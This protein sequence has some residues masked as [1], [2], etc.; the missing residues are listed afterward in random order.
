MKIWRLITLCFLFVSNGSYSQSFVFGEKKY[1]S[2]PG[3]SIFPYF[4]DGHISYGRLDANRYYKVWAG[5]TSY[6]TVGNSYF[7]QDSIWGQGL[8]RGDSADFDNGGAWL[9][10][11]FI[12]DSNYWLGFYHAED[13][14]FPG[15]ANREQIAWKSIAQCVSFD[16]GRTWEKRGQIITTDQIKPNKPTWGGHADFTVV[17]DSQNKR[18]IAYFVVPEGLGMAISEDSFARA[19]TWKKHYNGSFTEPG[20]GGMASALNFS[21]DFRRGGNPSI[22]YSKKWNKWIMVYHD[23]NLRGIYL[24]TSMDLINWD[25]PILLVEN[26]SLIGKI[27]YP[28]LVGENSDM[29]SDSILWLSYAEFPNNAIPERKYITRKLVFIDESAENQ[30]FVNRMLLV[31]SSIV[32]IKIYSSSGLLTETWYDKV[33]LGP[34]EYDFPWKEFKRTGVFIL[35]TEINQVKKTFKVVR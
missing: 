31:D 22:I 26:N 9:Y 23:W 35:S 10:S 5:S 17:R 14:L 16:R 4:P 33:H 30:V 25:F 28:N 19:G 13:H 29:H 15:F 20:I 24:T 6:I 7:N 2:N 27:W 8:K 12:L 11:V 3:I 1:I 18:W 32:T 21:K 34:G